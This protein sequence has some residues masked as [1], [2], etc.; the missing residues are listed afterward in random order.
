MDA[1][2]AASNVR[3]RIIQAE[4][5]IA[6]LERDAHRLEN[7]IAAANQ[8]VETFGGQRGQIS[9]EFDSAQQKVTGDCGADRRN[10][11]PA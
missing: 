5:R 10:A 11:Q 2:S 3:N 6:A 1:V 9:F 8:Q 4:E 7:E